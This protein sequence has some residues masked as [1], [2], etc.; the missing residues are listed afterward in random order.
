M[1]QTIFSALMSATFENTNF[2]LSDYLAKNGAGHEKLELELYHAFPENEREALGGLLD[3]QATDCNM[4]LEAGIATGIYIA[5]ALFK[6]L[7][8]P[9]EVLTAY[10]STFK[11]EDANKEAIQLIENY[12]K[13]KGAGQNG[14]K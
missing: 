12:L 4:Y 5:N 1:T 11:N 9:F 3:I 8:S 7:Q 13:Q 2:P 10:T 14:Q 6:I